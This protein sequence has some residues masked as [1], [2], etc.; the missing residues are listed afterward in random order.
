[1]SAMFAVLIKGL[2]LV[3]GFSEMWRISGEGGRLNLFNFSAN[4]FERHTFWNLL[5]GSII[6]SGSP[7]MTS[8]YLIHRTLCLST[9][10]KGRWSIYVTFCGQII[11]L[12]VIGLTGLTLYSFYQVIK[13]LDL[14]SNVN[15][16]FLT[17]STLVK[18]WIQFLFLC[19]P[20][21][22]IS[23]MILRN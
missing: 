18:G 21:G 22:L 4:V 16:Y 14:P 12:S 19:F 9:P 17:K 13:I 23:S 20:S 6:L 5:F 11:F 7:Y 15:F 2:M 8:Q 10:E 1:M 3:G